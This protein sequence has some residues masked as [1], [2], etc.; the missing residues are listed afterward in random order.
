MSAIVDLVLVLV[1]LAVTVAGYRRG[2]VRSA[3]A[4]AGL[5]VGGVAAAIL[6]PKVGDWVGDPTSRLLVTVVVAVVLL[7]AG[8]AIGA[9]IGALIGRGLLR[10]PLGLIDRVLG[11]AVALVIAVLVT[12]VAAGT[13]AQLGV[14]FLAGPLASSVVLRTIDAAT[15]PQVQSA[16]AALRSAAVQ[17]SIPE[18]QSALG[19]VQG[20]ATAPAAVSTAALTAAAKSVVKV[21]GTAY[22]CGQ[23]QSGTGFVIAPGR[24]LTNAHVVSGVHSPV[25]LDSDGAAHIGTIVYFDARSDLAV[26]S[27]PSLKAATLPVAGSVSAGDT[28]VVDG[29]P[30]GGPFQTTG[31]KVEAVTVAAIAN[32]GVSGDSDRHI[33]ALA[34][35]I[36]Q[37]NSGGPLLSPKG[38]V[39]GI[40]F[41]KSATEQDVGYAMTPA[42]F[43]GVVAKAP[44]LKSAVSSG[45]CTKD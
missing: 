21:T 15:P 2:L 45:A 6:C 17:G 1:L 23:S 24:V 9:T 28:G 26:I 29:Y 20:G 5:V 38:A 43:D 35:D 36:E 39:L 11:G 14:P 3:G 33:A 37:G 8:S 19:A 12:S 13:V 27:A 42:Q 18:I 16:L 7:L 4:I 41:A 25:V 34:A 10:G 31:A 22:A 32:I 44:S 30:F 40:V